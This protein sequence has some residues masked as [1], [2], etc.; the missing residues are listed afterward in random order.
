MLAMG[1]A[2]DES[3]SYPARS[4][5]T[6]LLLTRPSSQRSL[7]RRLSWP[8]IAECLQVSETK[9]DLNELAARWLRHDERGDVDFP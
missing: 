8:D 5:G 4:L 2:Q 7:R 1:I 6:L 3:L 9:V